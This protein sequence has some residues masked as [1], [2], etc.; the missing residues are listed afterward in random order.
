VIMSQKPVLPGLALLP[1]PP[2]S[3]VLSLLSLQSLNLKFVPSASRLKGQKAPPDRN[4][5]S[6]GREKAENGIAK[7]GKSLLPPNWRQA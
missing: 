2:E 6:R 1:K 5:E 3:P 4:L 7:P